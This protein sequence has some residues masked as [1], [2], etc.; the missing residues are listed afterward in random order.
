MPIEMPEARAVELLTKYEPLVRAEANRLFRV[1][2]RSTNAAGIDDLCAEGRVAV[3]EAMSRFQQLNVNEVS[4]VRTRVHHR[5]IDMI[6]RFLLGSR[7]ELVSAKK[8]G[9]AFNR[10]AVPIDYSPDG[11][12]APEDWLSAEPTPRD[13]ESKLLGRVESVMHVLS[14]S[15]R[16]VLRGVLFDG[17]SL[18]ELAGQ[19]GIS[20]G[21][22]C[23]LKK[24]A[25]RKV[26]EALST[27]PDL[28]KKPRPSARRAA[29]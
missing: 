4:W 15:E 27:P 20:V 26:R 28:A 8:E 5:M 9:R 6:R 25:A 16:H 7:K 19:L 11:G 2:Q 18:T 23:Q 1:L 29:A 3:L 10:T 21:R 17:T 24:Q 13:Y 14:S 12:P 22:A